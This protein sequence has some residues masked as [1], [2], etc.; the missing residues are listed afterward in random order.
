M[1]TRLTGGSTAKMYLFSGHDTTIMA[2][3]GAMGESIYS[4][5]LD[6]LCK[7][8]INFLKQ[9]HSLTVLFAVHLTNCPAGIPSYASSVEF[10]LYSDAT[11]RVLYVSLSPSYA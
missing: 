3:L 8:Q 7:F 11:V 6:K 10:E 9:C 5:N 1:E 2:L 4:T